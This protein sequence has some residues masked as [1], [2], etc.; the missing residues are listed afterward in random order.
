MVSEDERE[1][2]LRTDK[3]EEQ[4]REGTREFSSAGSRSD[5]WPGPFRSWHIDS[6]EW[7]MVRGRKRSRWRLSVPS[8][9]HSSRS[10]LGV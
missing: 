10:A 8:F 6:M 1:H 3:R 4:G 7:R 2:N 5:S 9:H